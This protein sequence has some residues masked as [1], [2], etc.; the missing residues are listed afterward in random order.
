MGGKTTSN[1]N[2]SYVLTSGD[3]PPRFI[4]NLIK[5]KMQKQL[6]LKG[7]EVLK[8]KGLAGTFKYDEKSKM[9]GQSYRRFAYDGAV[10]VANTQ[11]E[12]CSLFDSGKLYSA[13]LNLEVDGDRSVLSLLNTTSTDQEINMAR[14]EA[15]LNSILTNFTPEA[16]S[17]E[18][19]QDIA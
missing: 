12:F 13:D 8:I 7:R 16:I 6:N 14:A 5:N 17:E 15:T 19:L 9:A 3:T 4:N 10:F 1:C 11:D 2:P 18:L